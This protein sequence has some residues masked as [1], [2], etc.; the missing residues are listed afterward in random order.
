MVRK[1]C[2]VRKIFRYILVLFFGTWS[3]DAACMP[4]ATGG[5]DNVVCTGTVSGFQYLYGGSDTISLQGVSGNG[6]YWL[7]KST[8]GDPATDGNDTFYA[9]ESHFYWVFGFGKNDY[10]EVNGSTFS[11]LYGDTNPYWVDQ[12]GDDTI[13]IRNSVSN[14][15]ICGGND[16]D[17]I[18]ISDSNVSNVGSGYSDVYGFD[19]TPFDGNDTIVLDNVNFTEPNYYY[20]AVP[21]AVGGGKD[22]DWIEMSRG[23]AYNVSGGHGNDII[24]IAEGTH[25]HQ[26][27]YVDD[28]G[29][30][31]LCGI[32]GD[33][34]YVLELNASHD[35]SYISSH[36]GD[37][38]ITIYDADLSGIVVNGGHGSDT[39][40]L[41]APVMLAGTYLDGGDDGSSADGF[42]DRV[43]FEQWAGDLNGSQFHNWE[44]VVLLNASNIT[45]SDTNITVSGDSG[46]FLS[47][48]YGLIL[49]D[50]SQLNLYHNFLVDGSLH[51]RAVLNLQDHNAS[52]TILEVSHD[53]TAEGGELY[54][55]TVLND[56]TSTISD[57]LRVKGSTAGNTVIYINNVGGSG[58][59]T[60]TGD[61]EG[62]LL[63]EVNGT[64]A[65]TFVLDDTVEAGDYLYR[66]KKGSNGNWYLQSEAKVYA[67][68]LSKVM[69]SNADEDDSGDITLNDT[70][71]YE[72]IAANTGNLIQYNV[73][74]TDTKITPSS[75]T[76]A[77][78][79]PSQSCKLTGTYTVTQADMEA[80]RVY[81]TASVSSDN[82]RK[83][84]VESIIKTSCFCNLW[85]SD[86]ADSLLLGTLVLEILFLIS[87][88]GLFLRQKTAGKR[89]SEVGAHDRTN[90]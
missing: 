1:G 20:P 44:Q 52:G 26:C 17:R 79:A 50:N 35:Q 39:L 77:S 7:D 21:G 75:V 18:E 9:S 31:R 54:L 11:N 80:G 55:D 25:F 72:V 70:L 42:V 62:I 10:F 57:V 38:N 23:E 63:I 33:V 76:C 88:G 34:D 15:W 65:G 37:D 89:M 12:R 51:N 47:R 78:L 27:S 14:G 30:S 3:A 81:N 86:N 73:T 71:T 5:D 64:S 68:S 48:P 60:G 24:I 4:A 19:Y 41:F 36:H 49:E 66:L 28:L 83:K 40:A 59:Q 13:I 58:G 2:T 61:N 90:K 67:L 46:I 6:V 53:Y 85:D 16:N 74:V 82:T 8:H 29:L 45:F 87:L 43:I 69:K 84:R 32:Y 22:D 56:G